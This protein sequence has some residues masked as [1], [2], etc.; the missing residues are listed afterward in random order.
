MPNGETTRG[1]KCLS[2]QVSSTKQEAMTCTTGSG[3]EDCHWLGFKRRKITGLPNEGI[4]LWGCEADKQ[5][6]TSP[7]LA[8]I[9]GG[10]LKSSIIT[11]WGKLDD[12]IWARRM[13]SHSFAFLFYIRVNKT[14]D[15]WPL[16]VVN[17]QTTSDTLSLQF[18]S[19]NTT[20]WA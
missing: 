10:Q 1:E 6:D 7:S 19:Y 3:C 11:Y 5:I 18:Y 9:F 8:S 16:Q 15:F 12:N 2:S 17:T 4:Y 14:L 20:F 13:I